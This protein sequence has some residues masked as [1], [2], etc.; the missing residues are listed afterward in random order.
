MCFCTPDTNYGKSIVLIDY[1][2][3]FTNVLIR[4]KT[5]KDAAP[6]GIGL[7]EPPY[8]PLAGVKVCVL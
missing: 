7:V 3:M 8:A 5:F 2:F 1:D 4:S 6:Y